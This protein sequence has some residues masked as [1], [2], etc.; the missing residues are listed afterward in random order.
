MAAGAR[1]AWEVAVL[2]LEGLEHSAVHMESNS[3]VDKLGP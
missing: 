2:M 3:L 1:D